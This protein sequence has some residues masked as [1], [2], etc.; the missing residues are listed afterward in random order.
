MS[1]PEPESVM[2]RL[3][4]VVEHRHQTR[5]GGSYT[6]ELFNDGHDVIA[7]KVVEE[8]YEL[9]AA[10]GEPDPV[11]RQAVTAE[12]ADLIYHVLVLLKSVDVSWKFVERELQQ[13]FGTSGLTEKANRP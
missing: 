7:A 4:A 3:A 11:D 10:A 1:E 12:A 5:P 2:S 8:A 9:I 13:R 6:A